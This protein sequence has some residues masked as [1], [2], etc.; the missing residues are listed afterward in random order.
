MAIDRRQFLRR[1]AITAVG[2][3][4]GSP[5]LER[6]AW[7][8]PRR[9]AKAA[10]NDKVI[11]TLNLFGGN[12]GL[13][14][15]VPLAQ[16]DRYRQLR[17]KIGIDREAA[18]PLQNAPDVA[19]NPG[20]T[21]IRDLYAQGRV[22]VVL[23][24]GV[25]PESRALFDHEGAQYEFQT[26]DVTHAGDTTAPTGWLG[27]WLDSVNEG[28]VS[29]GIDFGGGSLVM[30]GRQREALTITSIDQ[31]QVQP[32]FDSDAR[33][34]A[35]DDIQGIPHTASGV[36]ER[37]R[38]I[39]LASIQQSSVVRE[40]TAGYEP[41]VE[42]PQDN[43]LAETLQ[44]TA[45]LI[46]ADLGVRG[47]AVGTDGYDTHAGQTDGGGDGELGYHDYL[48]N[49]WSEAVSAFYFDLA[50]HGQADRVVLLTMS[51]FGRRPEENNDL[52][53]DHG[54]ASV[55]FAVGNPVRGGVYGEYPSLDEDRLVFDGNVDITTD[56]RRVYAT[57]L[58]PYLG[59]DPGPVLGGSFE[60]LGF[61]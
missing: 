38:Q 29:P 20:M 21:A 60:P 58:G 1:S 34:A 33:T 50:A 61:L 44:Q 40:A 16:Y 14:T 4:F 56:F 27:R 31:F 23:G 19:L 30:T 47:V 55:M 2:L 9:A 57:V 5:L 18:L 15:V 32:G 26:A 11:V 13:N 51:E 3:S 52:G 46:T 8:A 36:G 28:T 6:V 10:S 42:Y 25:P 22:A 12:D 39:R 53:T 35:Y 59:A 41:A 49:T 24:A 17:P 43:Y 37:N 7:G 54:Y 45:K 48:L